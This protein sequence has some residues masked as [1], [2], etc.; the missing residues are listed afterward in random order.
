MSQNRADDERAILNT[1]CEFPRIVDRHEWHRVSEVFADDIE[2][3]YGDGREQRGLPAL[4]DQFQQFHERCSAMQH[5][6][7]SIQVELDGDSAVTN[8]YVQ[9]RH[10]GKDDRAHLF[11]DTNGEYCDRWQRRPEGWRIVRRDARWAMFMGDPS[12]LFD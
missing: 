7:G 8:T 4:L 6:L 11:F 12:V 10:Q 1:L 5:L 3:N 2:F 9:A